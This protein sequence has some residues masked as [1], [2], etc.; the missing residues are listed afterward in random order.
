[1]IVSHLQ[2]MT[3]WHRHWAR[4]PEIPQRPSAR[5]PPTLAREAMPL[6]SNDAFLVALKGLFEQQQARA[7]GKG[8]IYVTLKGA[9]TRRGEGG[10]PVCLYRATD[11]RL[12][13]IST[14][15]LGE[16]SARFHPLCM[17]LLKVRAALALLFSLPARVDPHHCALHPSPPP[18]FYYYY[19]PR[20]ARA[21]VHE[22]AQEGGKEEGGGAVQGCRGGQ[23]QVTL[24]AL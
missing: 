8:S 15:V 24:C 22:R 20:N 3:H 16:D 10:R 14:H 11:G 23:R 18:L 5:N 1:M 13:K 7:S 4:A 19:L 6:L 2:V 9:S 17:S 21:D 12:R